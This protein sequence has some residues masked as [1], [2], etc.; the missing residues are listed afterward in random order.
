M[1]A[2]FFLFVFAARD[3]ASSCAAPAAIQAVLKASCEAAL[4]IKTRQMLSR[5]LTP[6]SRS[7][8]PSLMTRRSANSFDGALNVIGELFPPTPAADR[9]QHN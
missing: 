9:T 8:K 3:L 6:K 1:K 4:V 2:F 5:C 7:K